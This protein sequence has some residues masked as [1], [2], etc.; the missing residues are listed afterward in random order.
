MSDLIPL[1]S[2]WLRAAGR[3]D[4]TITAR[5]RLLHHANTHLPKGIDEAHTDEWAAYLANQ[6]WSP[7]T[8][9]TYY[10]HA[11]GYYQW[12]IYEAYRLN[13][14]NPID[15]L[16]RP[17][18]GDRLPDPASAEELATAL[19]LLPAMPWRMAVML[20]AYAGLRCCEI[21][22]VERRDCT[23][24]WLRVRGKGG[25]LAAVPMSPVLWAVVEPMP[26][27]LLVVG[28]R[29]RPLTAQM[30]TQMQGRVWARIGQ[31]HQ[32]LHRFRHWAGT[33]VQRG[34]GD[35]RVTQRFL[36]HAS[37]RSTEGYTLVSATQLRAA[38]AALP[39]V[40]APASA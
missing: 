25:R 13:P 2:L 10:H 8:R 37:V 36:R 16:I 6:A 38:V 15:G 34:C 32:H 35:I 28:A 24:D 9:H 20:A 11:N 23:T 30:L 39:A 3:S 18:E 7:W 22:T 1:H 33:E 27:G 17:P 26:P 5:E 40:G 14:P 21:V 19:T 29:G 31:P 4:R 12:A